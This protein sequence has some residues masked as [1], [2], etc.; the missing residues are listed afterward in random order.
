MINKIFYLGIPGSNSFLAATNVAQNSGNLQG[1]GSFA[2]IVKKTEK[3]VRSLGIL[4]IEN[5]LSGS[6]FEVFDLLAKSNVSIRAEQIISINHALMGREETFINKIRHCLSHPEVFRQCRQFFLKHPEIEIVAVSDSASA[7]KMLKDSGPEFA[8]IANPIAASAHN[9]KIIKEH[10]E[11][12]RRNYSRFITI[13]RKLRRKGNK[14][15][16]TFNLR[17]IPGSLYKAL[18]PFARL[19][20]NITKIESR[21]IPGKLWEYLFY[22]DFEIN[23]KKHNFRD[24]IREMKKYTKNLK[25]LGRY[26]ASK[27]N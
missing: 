10:L 20:L 23:E 24:I 3:D 5:S 14:I 1:L 17:H 8:A 4:P 27:F 21:P 22:V 11:D 9:L 16:L 12:R 6:I 2:E 26:E 7:A 13:G 15:S 18:S 25:V 19:G